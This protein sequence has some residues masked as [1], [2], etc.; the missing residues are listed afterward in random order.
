MTG[1][2]QSAKALQAVEDILTGIFGRVGLQT[3]TKKTET[4][5]FLPG[6]LCI[7]LSDMA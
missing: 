6:K 7:S 1:S 2:L 5:T 3:N 4:M